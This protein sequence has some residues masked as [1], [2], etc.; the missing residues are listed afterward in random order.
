MLYK[1]AMKLIQFGTVRL[2]VCIML[3]QFA[4]LQNQLRKIFQPLTSKLLEAAPR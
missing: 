2:T 3:G 1:K 4:Q